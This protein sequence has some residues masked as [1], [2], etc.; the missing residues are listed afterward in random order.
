ME[1]LALAVAP[2][3][4]CVFYVYIR[5]KY[6]KEPIK[7]LA[8]GVVLGVAITFPIVQTENFVMRFTPDSGVLAESFFLSFVNASLV[9]EAFKFAI[10]FFLI[11]RNRNFNERF[12]G[13]VYAVFI[14]LGFAGLENV[15]YVFNPDMGGA[16]TAL[17]RA[18]FSVPGHALFG[19]AMGFY[20]AMA[21]FAEAPKA[22]RAWYF[23]MALA[24]PLL[25]HG[26]YDFILMSDMPYLMVVFVLYVVY[27]WING[28]RQMRIHVGASPFKALRRG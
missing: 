12:D 26:V 25:L 5:D 16:E 15:L 23:S 18:V 10:L 1:L 19:V 17:A 14:S 13:I 28:L 27:L 20:F 21:R 8:V 3:L 9:E 6:E 24:V 4:I 7:L 11:W 2:V 22:R